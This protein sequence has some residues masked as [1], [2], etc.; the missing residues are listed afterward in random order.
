MTLRIAAAFE[1][2]ISST[3]GPKSAATVHNSHA[4]VPETGPE[5]PAR[6]QIRKCPERPGTHSAAQ[7]RT[8]TKAEAMTLDERLNIAKWLNGNRF[9]IDSH[10]DAPPCTG[11]TESTP[12]RTRT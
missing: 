2:T 8:T 11:Q 10:E 5:S 12:L 3:I 6:K 1:G 4:S 7:P 9:R